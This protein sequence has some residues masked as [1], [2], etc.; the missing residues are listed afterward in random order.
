MPSWVQAAR[1]S[2]RRSRDGLPCKGWAMYGQRVCR[3]HGGAAP[4]NRRR[5]AERV[6]R[7]KLDRGFRADWKRYQDQLAEWE[8]ARRRRAARHLGCDPSEL[9]SAQ[10]SAAAGWWADVPG[11]DQAPEFRLDGRRVPRADL[12]DLFENEA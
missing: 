7:M 2:A 5:G 4:Q 1:C 9:T 6:A 12:A 11:V 10:L 3:A 8:E